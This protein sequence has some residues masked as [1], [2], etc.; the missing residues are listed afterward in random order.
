MQIKY[1]KFDHEILILISIA[2]KSRRTLFL[3][4]LRAPLFKSKRTQSNLPFWAAYISAVE[5]SCACKYNEFTAHATTY[6][7]Y[8][9]RSMRTLTLTFDSWPRVRVRIRIVNAYANCNALIITYL[10]LYMYRYRLIMRKHVH[11]Q[12]NISINWKW[13]LAIDWRTSLANSIWAP[14]FNASIKLSAW[15]L[16]AA[17]NNWS[18]MEWKNSIAKYKLHAQL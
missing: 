16:L 14:S 10:Y 12:A 9:Y 17:F 7:Y 1:I 2:I 18:C 8:I 11:V 6:I 15:P 4:S 13:K 3:A 5:P